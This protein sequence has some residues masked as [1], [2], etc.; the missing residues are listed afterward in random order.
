MAKKRILDDAEVVYCRDCKHRGEEVYQFIYKCK[1]GVNPS[2]G[3]FKL[4]CKY[5]TK[6]AV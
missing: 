1:K 6:H 2:H 3:N 5:F 4:T